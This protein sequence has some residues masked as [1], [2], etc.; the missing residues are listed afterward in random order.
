MPISI[1]MPALEMAQESG[2]LVAWR[3]KEGDHVAKGEPLLEV[4]TDKAVLEIESPGDGIL[5]G[6]TA[7]PGDVVAVG[8]TIAWLVAPGEAIPASLMSRTPEDPPSPR[9]SPSQPGLANVE[10]PPTVETPPD[11][12]DSPTV[13][14]P[15][16]LPNTGDPATLVNTAD[17][18][19]QE[20]AKMASPKARRL[21]KERG[22]DLSSVRG[23][24]PHGEIPVSDIERAATAAARPIVTAAEPVEA[25]GSVGRLMAER[26]VQSWTTVPH[27]FVRRDVDASAFLATHSQSA[28]DVEKAHQVVSTYTDLLVLLIARTLP[29]H[30]RLN[31]SWDQGRIRLHREVNIGLA[32]SVD[33]GTVVVVFQNADRMTLAEVAVKRRELVERA[34]AGRL[35]PSDISGATFTISNLGMFQIDAFTAIIVP[36]QAGILAVGA[37]ASRVVALDND[38]VGV[39]PMATLTLSCDHRVVDGARAAAFLNDVATAIRH[40]QL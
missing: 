2:T 9:S 38:G 28:P 17:V 27:F 36:P 18:F 20:V 6:V 4:E 32:V 24:G 23:S 12:A 7:V 3:K 29:G 33:A 11:L 31:A 40:P 22:V 37:I 30:P 16:D 25:L 15:P 21:A 26:M 5:T 13:V 19:S 1:V 39:R 35:H 8:K 14:D 34:R 10:G